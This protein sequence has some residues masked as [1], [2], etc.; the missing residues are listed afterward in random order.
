[1][2]SAGAGVVTAALSHVVGDNTN[3][4][5]MA[6]MIVFHIH[7]LLALCFPPVPVLSPAFC[8]MLLVTTPTMAEMIV[9]YIH[10]AG[11]LFHASAGVVT[12]ALSDVVGDNT[13][14]GK[15][16]CP[17]KVKSRFCGVVEGLGRV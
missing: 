2:F 10:L 12:G 6:E 17:A 9:F 1:M 16:K 7:L 5:G 8:R 3:N 13:N 14:N 4:G 11:T 15:F